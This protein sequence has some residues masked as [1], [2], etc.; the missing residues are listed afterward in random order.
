MTKEGFLQT[1]LR[2]NSGA[3]IVLTIYPAGYIINLQTTIH[4]SLLK[5]TFIIKTGSGVI[6]ILFMLISGEQEIY[7]AIKC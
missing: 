4:I 1:R 6:Y 5:K 3:K 2:C 7:S